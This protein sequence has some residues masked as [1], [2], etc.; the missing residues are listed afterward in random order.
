MSTINRS[1][2][3]VL[4][5]EVLW[6][7]AKRERLKCEVSDLLTFALRR[8]SH[9]NGYSESYK[10]TGY[11]SLTIN[12][13]T[14]SDLLT[15]AI[16]RP[17]AI[18]RHSHINGYSDSYKVTGYTFLTM[19]CKDTAKQVLLCFWTQERTETVQLCSGWFCRQ[20]WGHKI[21]SSIDVGIYKIWHYVRNT[22]TTIHTRRLIVSFRHSTKYVYW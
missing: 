22:N 19:N 6:H 1:G 3:G 20:W 17:F 10:V 14:N 8:H 9:S 16:W 4:P 7:C 5:D 11:T 18:W 21:L 13:K 12:C 2:V 15:F